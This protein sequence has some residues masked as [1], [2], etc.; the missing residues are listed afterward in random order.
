MRFLPLFFIFKEGKFTSYQTLEEA[1]ADSVNYAE[2]AGVTKEQALEHA[3]KVLPT[4]KRW[5][6]D[7]KDNW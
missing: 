2:V 6:C 1:I 5:R 3:K 4:L 7:V